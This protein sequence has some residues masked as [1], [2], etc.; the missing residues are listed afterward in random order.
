MLWCYW[1][2]CDILFFV[3][4]CLRGNVMACVLK[5]RKFILIS[6]FEWLVIWYLTP[7]M[8]NI[9]YLSFLLQLCDGWRLWLYQ[10]RLSCSLPQFPLLPDFFECL[11]IG[12][13][14]RRNEQV[15]RNCVNFGLTFELKL[16]PWCTRD[17]VRVSGL[18]RERVHFS[19]PRLAIHTS[20]TIMKNESWQRS[21][22]NKT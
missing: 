19:S 15:G 8:I 1:V 16:I 21:Y 14:P 3:I 13:T 10:Y 5:E 2:M 18:A 9:V 4:I 22:Y 11:C 12:Q 7:L 17:E 6:L 20:A